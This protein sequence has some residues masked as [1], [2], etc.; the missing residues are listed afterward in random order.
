M[1]TE[2]MTLLIGLLVTGL[3]I[4]LILLGSR[5]PGQIPPASDPDP[6]GTEDS[7]SRLP[8][9]PESLSEDILPRDSEL[10]AQQAEP[11]PFSPS[12]Q[13]DSDKATEAVERTASDDSDRKAGQKDHLPAAPLTVM[14]TRTFR[15]VVSADHEATTAERRRSRQLLGSALDIDLFE[16]KKLLERRPAA[17]RGVL[18]DVTESIVVEELA[19]VRSYLR[20]AFAGLDTRLREGPVH[21][22]DPALVAFLTSGLARLPVH[23]GPVFH[24]AGRD[25]IRLDALFPGSLL[26]EPGFMQ[27]RR[28]AYPAA[29]MTSGAPVTYAIWSETGRCA[30]LLA[31]HEATVL[32]T[33]TTRFRV[34]AVQSAPDKDDVMVFLAQEPAR[35]GARQQREHQIL[36]QLRRRANEV[37]IGPL[38]GLS[39]SAVAHPGLDATGRAFT[40]QMTPTES[41]AS[42]PIPT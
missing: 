42:Q 11:A 30:P 19:M 8:E 34:L 4:L 15:P 6:L 18:I 20:G 10:P 3:G 27:T 38:D 31:G 23:H 29:G 25:S 33:P 40:P 1:R 24:R 14:Q 22:S 35:V 32:F 12:A 41:A 21:D 36:D 2:I 37:G 28:D 26:I 9:S 39:P 16:I 13:P 17:L 5:G 7:D